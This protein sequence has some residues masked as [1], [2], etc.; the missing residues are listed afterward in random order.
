MFTDLFAFP[1]E[2][3]EDVAEDGGLL[4]PTLVV[5]VLGVVSAVSGIPVAQATVRALPQQAQAFSGI[6]YVSAIVGGLVGPV[7]VWLIYAGVFH[8]ISSLAFDG[9]G[10]FGTT[11][12]VTGWGFVPAVLSAAISGVLGWYALRT[13][14]IPTGPAQLSTFLAQYYANP[15]VVVGT[16]ISVVFL[17]WQAYLWTIGLQHAR[18]LSRRDAAITVAI[19]VAVAL[20]F[21]LYGLLQAHLLF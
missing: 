20:L 14:G 18:H 8:G 13:I 2:F 15:F 21:R 16:V 17:L 7:V 11:L 9:D 3:F 12:A 19:P 1:D 5:V 10:S 4:R 6:V